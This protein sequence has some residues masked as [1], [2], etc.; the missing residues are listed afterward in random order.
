MRKSRFW[1]VLGDLCRTEMRDLCLQGVGAHQGFSG[2]LSQS[3][4]DGSTVEIGQTGRKPRLGVAGL[5][6]RCGW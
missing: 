5:C 6:L 2:V 3:Q 4:S 1:S